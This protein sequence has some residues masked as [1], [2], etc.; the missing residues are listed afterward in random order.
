[1][2]PAAAASLTAAL[3]PPKILNRGYRGPPSGGLFIWPALPLVAGLDAVQISIVRV[4]LSCDLNLSV[5]VY[6]VFQGRTE[7]AEKP[8]F[9]TARS[10]TIIPQM[11]TSFRSDSGK[12]RDLTVRLLA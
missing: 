4:M 7:G 1:M 2:A 3:R 6:P 10:V 11:Q 12:C 9:A 5:D 8:G